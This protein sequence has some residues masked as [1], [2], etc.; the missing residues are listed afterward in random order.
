MELVTHM[1]AG[2]DAGAPI[3]LV[4]ESS[5]V[6]VQWRVDGTSLVAPEDD[7]DAILLRDPPSPHG[8]WQK[9][10]GPGTISSFGEATPG[11]LGRPSWWVLYGHAGPS[12]DVRVHIDEDDVPDP[13]VHRVGGVWACEWVSYPTFAEI[14]RSDRDRTDRVSFER[15]MFMPPAPHPE[16]EIRQ[17]RRGRGSGKSV[18]NR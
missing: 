16:V 5:R 6:V 15:P 3:R 8:I 14:H 7:L 11:E 10:L 13:V 1:N 4:L 17:R 9:P 2:D 18:E 12:V